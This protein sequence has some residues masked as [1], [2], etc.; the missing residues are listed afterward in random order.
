MTQSTK[1]ES[2][3]V[4]YMDTVIIDQTRR[5]INSTE[6]LNLSEQIEIW[7]AEYWRKN[8][9]KKAKNA[10]AEWYVDRL[11]RHMLKIL[12]GDKDYGGK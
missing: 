6:P 8:F 1:E 12:I 9:R 3:L 11:D 5:A 2:P 7:Y 4:P 10:L